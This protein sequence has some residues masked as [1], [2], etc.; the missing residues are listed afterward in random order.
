MDTSGFV[1][2]PPAGVRTKRNYW[3]DLSLFE[4]GYVEA[5][6]KALRDKHSFRNQPLV[7]EAIS[8]YGFSDLA[9]ETLAAILKDCAAFGQTWRMQEPEGARPGPGFAR[10][11]QGGRDFWMMRQRGALT[12]P[13]FPPLI[14]TIRDDGKIYL[15][16]KEGA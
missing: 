15:T 14:L 12:D 10:G 8:K 2:G 11:E 1:E 16:A 13:P 7:R 4:Q 5:L 6:F 9:P 3:P